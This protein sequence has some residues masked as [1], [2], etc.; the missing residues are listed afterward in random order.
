MTGTPVS[1][2]LVAPIGAEGDA[3]RTALAAIDGVHSDGPL[4]TIFVERAL[5]RDGMQ[6]GYGADPPYRLVVGASAIFPAFAFVHEVGHVLD[7]HGLGNGTAFAADASSQLAR[8]R[9]AVRSSR[10]HAIVNALSKSTT[11]PA[12][13]TAYAAY[14]IRDIELWARSYQQFIALRSRDAALLQ[15]LDAHRRRPPGGKLYIPTY[16]DDDDFAPIAAAIEKLFRRLGWI[17]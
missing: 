15:A 1:S 3:I 14:A 7:H 10:A 5:L 13:V 9:T 4:P 16:W 8:W 11:L 12:E 6:G 2:A 17:A